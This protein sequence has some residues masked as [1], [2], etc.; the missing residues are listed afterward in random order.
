MFC[1]FYSDTKSALNFALNFQDRIFAKFLRVHKSAFFVKHAPIGSKTKKLFN[2][3]V[4]EL[5]FA[6]STAA[7][8]KV[9]KIVAPYF[10]T[11]QKP[12]KS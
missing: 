10:T 6:T 11:F 8:N 2:K 3:R 4:F 5:K 9:V 1:N 7:D 12:R